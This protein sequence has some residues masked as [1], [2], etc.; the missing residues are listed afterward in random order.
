MA[1]YVELT[2]YARKNMVITAVLR[3]LRMR[4]IIAR[5]F[6]YYKQKKNHNSTSGP[7]ARSSS[8]TMFPEIL[9]PGECFLVQPSFRY[10]SSL[11]NYDREEKKCLPLNHS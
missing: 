6:N 9:R 1:F 8:R 7:G 2:L 11:D 10:L 3:H 4:K 5:A